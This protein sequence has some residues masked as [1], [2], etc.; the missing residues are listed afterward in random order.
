[1]SYATIL[2]SVLYLLWHLVR[3]YLSLSLNVKYLKV[4]LWLPF[5]SLISL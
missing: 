1:M 3:L 2:E 4:I 5:E